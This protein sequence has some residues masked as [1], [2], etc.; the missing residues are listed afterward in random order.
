MTQLAFSQIDTSKM[1]YTHLAWLELVDSGDVTSNLEVD[2][3]IS[4]EIWSPAE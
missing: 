1:S 4:I 2:I 3:L